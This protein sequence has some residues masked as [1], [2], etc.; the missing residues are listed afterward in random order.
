MMRRGLPI[1]IDLGGVSQGWRRGCLE[2]SLEV[3]DGNL[4]H[5]K[6]RAC[7]LGLSG[8]RAIGRATRTLAG[9]CISAILDTLDHLIAKSS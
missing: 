9:V 7:R 2:G 1:L 4:F 3:S 5:T 8:W 6:T